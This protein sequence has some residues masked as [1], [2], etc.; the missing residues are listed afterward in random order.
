MTAAGP[1]RARTDGA[2]CLVEADET[3]AAL[4]MR[5]GGAYPG[6]IALPGLLALVRKARR[7]GT[8]LHAM[9][10][11]E[12]GDQPVSFQ[13]AVV[14][15]EDGA[16][17]EITQWRLSDAAWSAD[18]GGPDML[19]LQRQLAQAH[20][21]LDA[22][23]RVIAG[24]VDAADLTELAAAL[25]QGFG[26]YWTDLVSVE[27]SSHR[28]PLHWRLLDDAA[29]SVE[30]SAR[31]WKTRILPLRNGGFELFL[32]AETV[33]A[34]PAEAWQAG[35]GD[36]VSQSPGPESNGA[37][38]NGLLGQTLAPALRVPV[39]RI[40]ANAETIRTRLA[41]PI[42]EPYVGY[43]GD[44]AEAGRHLLSLVED[45]ADLETVEDANF[46]PAPDH[47][48]LADCARR[49]AGILGVRARERAIT[50]QLPPSDLAAPAIGEFKR[51]LQILLN[52]VGNAIRYTRPETSVRVESGVSGALAW[53]TVEDDGEGIGPEQAE[54]VFEKFERLGRS[55]DG[56]SGLGLYI[57]RKLA[58]AM[59]GNLVVERG[60][61]G[62]ARFVL[63]LPADRAAAAAETASAFG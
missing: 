47:V 34:S 28:Q 20:L 61:N 4:Q 17:I 15:L 16:T 39:N 29:V 40:V 32:V 54:R 51:V 11:V 30:G 60:T 24:N 63:T 62:G 45:L 42:A 59:G 3:F 46:A 36:E 21:V 18:N 19:A 5:L 10:S 41:G 2:D 58:R 49:A 13:A 7:T 6:T 1:I 9:L 23:Q 48:D 44:I 33:M 8:A 55:G 43:A 27:G 25:Q 14:P 37:P 53:I 12:D 22:E 31:T 26:R 57:S 38:L 52:L 56:G 35:S 50:L